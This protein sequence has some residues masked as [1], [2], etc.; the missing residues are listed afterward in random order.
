VR[1]RVLLYVVLEHLDQLLH[2][3]T[4]QKV[5]WLEGELPH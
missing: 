3:L 2:D 1:P 4:V 5:E